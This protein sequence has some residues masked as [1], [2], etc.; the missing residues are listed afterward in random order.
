MR[1]KT[2]PTFFFK[3]DYAEEFHTTDIMGIKRGRKNVKGAQLKQLY[4]EPPKISAAKHADL[5]SL[6]KDR[7]IRS[8]YHP[9][10]IS[11]KHTVNV[12]DTLPEADIVDSK[13]D[14]ME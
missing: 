2:Q 13:A 3:Y 5:M 14:I 7:A 1:G 11:V 8:D 9:F 10:Y 12:K 4:T 6:C